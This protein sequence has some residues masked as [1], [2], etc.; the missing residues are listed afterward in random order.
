MKSPVTVW[1]E[2]LSAVRKQQLER[3]LRHLFLNTPIDKPLSIGE[4]LSHLCIPPVVGHSF[5]PRHL[6]LASILA[7]LQEARL[8]RRILRV[9]LKDSEVSHDFSKLEDIPDS[10]GDPPEHISIEDVFVLFTRGPALRVT[11]PA[12]RHFASKLRE[13]VRVRT[14]TP[15]TLR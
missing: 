7:Q 5:H 1:R 2:W 8:L 9:T 15:T 4:I 13:L 6:T 14:S 10:I 11:S 12:W 3:A